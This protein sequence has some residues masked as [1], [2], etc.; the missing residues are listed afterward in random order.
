MNHLIPEQTSDQKLTEKSNRLKCHVDHA[1]L[2]VKS[3]Y[4][5]IPVRTK[6]HE[7]CN[8]DRQL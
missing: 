2:N 3:I 5:H 4:Y 1:I 7:H 8:T 6:V